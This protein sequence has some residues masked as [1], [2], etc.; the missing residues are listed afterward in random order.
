MR[1]LESL[2]Q[3]QNLSTVYDVVEIF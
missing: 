3:E 2:V 1:P